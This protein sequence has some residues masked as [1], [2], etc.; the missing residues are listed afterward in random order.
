MGAGG[1][2][3]ALSY[4]TCGAVVWAKGPPQEVRVRR[5]A[6]EGAGAW[7]GA[8][9][10]WLVAPFPAPLRELPGPVSERA[11]HRGYRLLK[12]GPF[13]RVRLIS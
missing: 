11:R 7:P 10:L 4:V 3:R 6:V 2:A 5:G 13:V 9:A 1:I 8:G 12:S